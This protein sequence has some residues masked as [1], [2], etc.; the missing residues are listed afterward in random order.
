LLSWVLVFVSAV[1]HQV[2]IIT[3]CNTIFYLDRKFYNPEKKINTD[4]VQ[5]AMVHN[6]IYDGP[7][8]ESV[9]HSHFDALTLAT[10]NN[11]SNSQLTQSPP[12]LLVYREASESPPTA[13]RYVEQ[14]LNNVLASE[15]TGVSDIEDKYTV[16]SPATV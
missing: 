2:N 10:I 6:P 9:L 4:T 1:V 13:E 7:V 14:P 8:Y 12:E 11:T 15:S 5:H 16:M 3:Y